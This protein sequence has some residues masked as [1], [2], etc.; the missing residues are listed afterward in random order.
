MRLLRCCSIE[1]KTFEMVVRGRSSGVWI[2]ES[3]RDYIPYM[4]LGKVDSH[5]LL[6]TV[7]ELPREIG[8][9]VF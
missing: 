9:L 6:A 1:S 7:E 8:T 4:F 5:W 3:C 2:R